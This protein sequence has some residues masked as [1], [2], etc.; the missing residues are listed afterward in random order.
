MLQFWELNVEREPLLCF[1]KVFLTSTDTGLLLLAL[2]DVQC[3][4]KTQKKA[5]CRFRVLIFFLRKIKLTIMIIQGI[6]ASALAFK[7]QA[8]HISCLFSVLGCKT[9]NIG[10]PRLP[11][12]RSYARP[13]VGSFLTSLL[14]WAIHIFVAGHLVFSSRVSS[15]FYSCTIST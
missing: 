11:D 1:S 9:L 13:S 6:A 2:H 4:A 8:C 10:P 12:L 3:G 15:L 7:Q 5:N 14:H